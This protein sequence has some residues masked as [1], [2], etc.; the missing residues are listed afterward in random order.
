M[1][2]NITIMP[3]VLRNFGA[4][5]RNFILAGT[6]YSDV[7]ILFFLPGGNNSVISLCSAR[8]P[9]PRRCVLQRRLSSIT[10][11]YDWWRMRR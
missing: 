3:V 11:A 9:T 1:T 5:T 4:T 6:L 8:N 2:V 10:E 7:F